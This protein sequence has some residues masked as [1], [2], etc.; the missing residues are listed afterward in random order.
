MQTSPTPPFADRLFDPEKRIAIL[1]TLTD[2]GLSLDTARRLLNE[3]SE[4]IAASEFA[5]EREAA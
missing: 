2:A 3:T 5:L 4:D 1:R